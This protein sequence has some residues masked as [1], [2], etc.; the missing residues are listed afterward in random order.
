MTERNQCIANELRISIGFLIFNIM[1][2]RFHLVNIKISKRI[3]ICPKHKKYTIMFKEEDERE[4]QGIL[5][6]DI[7]HFFHQF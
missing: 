6:A 1:P 7:L 2:S 5:A 3:K 4:R